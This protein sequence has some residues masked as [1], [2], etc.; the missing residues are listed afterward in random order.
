MTR[1]TLEGIKAMRPKPDWR[2]IAATTEK[3]I[4]RHM[5]EDREASVTSDGALR[6][7]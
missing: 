1:T 4:D 6:K 7:E 2:K 3:D 5:R